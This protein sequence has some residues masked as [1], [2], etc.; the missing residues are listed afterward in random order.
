[1]SISPPRTGRELED[2]KY[3]SWCKELRPMDWFLRR[4]GQ[5][6]FVVAGRAHASEPL[7]PRVE[8][9][10][11]HSCMALAAIEGRNWM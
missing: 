10:Y 1:V 6:F 5:P 8:S 4:F 7:V 9:E 11:C 2:E 3:C